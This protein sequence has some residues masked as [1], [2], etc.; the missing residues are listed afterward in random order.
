MEPL[1]R[2]WP[3]DIPV[4]FG[5]AT[6]AAAEGLAVPPHKDGDGD[7]DEQDAC[8]LELDECMR[9]LGDIKPQVGGDRVHLVS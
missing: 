5:D 3:V 1:P 9:V 8:M 2:L 7:G 4:L 6:S